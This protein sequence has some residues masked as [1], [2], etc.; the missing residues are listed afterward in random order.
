MKT[1]KEKLLVLQI[2]RGLAIILVLFCHAIAQINTDV[3]LEAIEEVITCFHMPIFFVIAGFLFQRGL[4][5]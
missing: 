5:R 3:L 2:M 1:A 4:S